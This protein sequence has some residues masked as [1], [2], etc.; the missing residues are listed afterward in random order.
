MQ[1][2]TPTL[3]IDHPGIKLQAL[4]RP[5][6][7]DIYAGPNEIN[8]TKYNVIKKKGRP[9]DGMIIAKQIIDNMF[10]SS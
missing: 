3:A 7:Y 2:V 8:V 6:G 5:V 4:Q 9:D 10:K 1:Y